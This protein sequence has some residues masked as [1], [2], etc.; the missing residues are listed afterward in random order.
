MPQFQFHETRM[1]ANFLERTMPELVKQLT[2]IADS[3]ERMGRESEVESP[4]S[5]TSPG[6]AGGPKTHGS[7]DQP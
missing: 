7:E 3:L 4:L 6:S 1:G 5:T 2:R